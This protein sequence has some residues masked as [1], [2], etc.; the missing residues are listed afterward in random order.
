MGVVYRAR[1]TRLNRQ[2]AIKVLPRILTED[3]QS[4]VRFKREALMMAA[5]NHPR[6]AGIYGLEETGMEHFLA[7]EWVEGETLAQ[8]LRKRDLGRE[9]ALRI[10]L[11]IAEGLEVAHAQGILHRDL[12]PDNIKITPQGNAKILDFGLAKPMRDWKADRMPPHE[13]ILL[14]SLS[15]PGFVLGTPAYMSPEQVLGEKVGERTDIWA[16]GCLLY[17][18]LTGTRAFRGKDLAEVR[19]SILKTEPNWNLLPADTP[20]SICVLVQRCL[21]KAP[22]RRLHH[23]L[24]ARQ[25]IAAVLDPPASG[26]REDDGKHVRIRKSILVAFAAALLILIALLLYLLARNWTG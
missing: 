8:F 20:K 23:I 7:I 13:P 6:I 2:V 22:Q 1:D 16:F 11:D 25:E 12:K 15:Q 3:K 14:D 26:T 4:L 24:R 10:C 19:V 18:C 21:Q 9:E 17:E 5:F